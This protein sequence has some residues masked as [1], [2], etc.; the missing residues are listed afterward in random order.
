MRDGV[1]DHFLEETAARFAQHGPVAREEWYHVV[2]PYPS[3]VEHGCHTQLARD[4]GDPP[5]GIRA[6]TRVAGLIQ[7]TG[8]D[9]SIEVAVCGLAR[10]PVCLRDSAR[11]PLRVAIDV[12]D[13]EGLDGSGAGSLH[14]TAFRR[15]GSILSTNFASHRLPHPIDCQLLARRIVNF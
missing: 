3:G 6:R 12:L 15:S 11:D 4:G 5:Q 8:V 1:F 13:D 14:K 9:Q 10:N 2:I 7:N